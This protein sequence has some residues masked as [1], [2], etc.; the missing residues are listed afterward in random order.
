MFAW[1]V[2]EGLRD[3]NPV[4]GTLTRV[5]VVRRQRL[6]LA[7]W[8]RIRNAAEPWFRNALDLALQ[9]LQRR[10]DLVA[11]RF[12]QVEDGRLLVRQQK[13]EGHGTGNIRIRVSRELGALIEDCR[14][15]LLSPYMI[16]RKPKR[17]RR[18]YLD[19]KEHWTQVQPEMLTREF[20][21][22]RDQCGL[23]KDLA[24]GQRPSFH[25]VRAL[26]ADLYREAGWPEDAIQRLLGHS[27]KK[28][29]DTY[30]DRHRERWVDADC[31]LHWQNSAA[32][33]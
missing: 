14:D 16:H 29:T 33:D 17:R 12:D 4:E 18:E 15:D 5:E 11:M 31:G 3:D 28:M 13:V 6:T 7:T 1:A 23:Y 27:S 25:E 20:K 10:E 8:R 24:A 22:L 26:G 9:T 2:A 21:R 32:T 19:R 30:L